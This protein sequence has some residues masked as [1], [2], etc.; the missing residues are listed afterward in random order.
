MRETNEQRSRKRY[1]ANQSD[2]CRR[3]HRKINSENSF[4][5]AVET[6]V[7]RAARLSGR[8]AQ[9]ETHKFIAHHGLV[10]IPTDSNGQSSE[11][12]PVVSQAWNFLWKNYLIFLIHTPPL[13]RGCNREVSRRQSHLIFMIEKHPDPSHVIASHGIRRG[14]IRC[15]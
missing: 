8:G 15:A 12:S 13:L 6:R 2:P 14:Q 3:T 1:A 7:T 11:T 4:I 9:E 10:F 5:H